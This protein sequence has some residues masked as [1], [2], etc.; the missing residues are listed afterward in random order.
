MARRMRARLRLSHKHRRMRAA[1]RH[2]PPCTLMPPPAPR[3]TCRYVSNEGTDITVSPAAGTKG[4]TICTIDGSG[5]LVQCKN[6]F[7]LLTDGTTAAWKA[8]RFV[9]LYGGKAF[10]IPTTVTTDGVV[11]CTDP[12]QVGSAGCTGG[13]SGTWAAWAGGSRAA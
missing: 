6:T 13:C 2:A 10:V 7:G 12:A 5:D 11:V 1:A 8:A 9:R 4:V 3:L